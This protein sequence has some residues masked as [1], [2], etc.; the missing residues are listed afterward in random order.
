MTDQD[1]TRVLAVGDL[2]GNL[3][4]TKRV[5]QESVEA[6]T[7][8]IL[9]LGDFGYWP[10]TPDGAR[11]LEAVSKDLQDADVNLF[12]IDGNHENFD[13]LDRIGALTAEAPFEIAQRI[14]YCP[15]IRLPGSL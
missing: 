6:G 2:H 11:F 5:I 9:Q 12:F 7:S 3:A 8:T 4:W 13:E 1:V 14:N 15:S 10:H